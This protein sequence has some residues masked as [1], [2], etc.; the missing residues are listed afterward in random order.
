M[1]AGVAERREAAYLP[2]VAAFESGAIDVQRFDHRA[3]LHV[4]WCYLREYPLAEAIARFTAAL[5]DLTVRVGAQGKYHETV[6]WF[7]M[8]LIA[9]RMAETPGGDWE[10]FGNANGDLMSDARGLLRRH[11][12][13]ECLASEH[14]RRHFVLPDRAGAARHLR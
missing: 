3:H 13:D 8:I 5:K 11:Y 14:A 1:S 10:A 12:S 4:G 9:E 7:F 6:S 2:D